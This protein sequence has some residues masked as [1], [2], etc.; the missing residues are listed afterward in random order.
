MRTYVRMGGLQLRWTGRTGSSTCSRS[1]TSPCRW[2]RPRACWCGHRACRSA[3][4]R[5]LVDEVV[6]AD[7]RLAWRSA[8]DIALAAWSETRPA[9]GAGGL[10]RR[11]P[12]DDRHAADARPHRRDRRRPHRGPG[13][14]GDVRAARRPRRAA[15]ARDQPPDGHRARA[16]CAAAGRSGP[17]LDAFLEFAGDAV[18]VAH[19]ARFDTAFLDAALRRRGG[20]RLACPVVDTVGLARRVLVPHSAAP[21]AAQPQ[22]ALRHDRASRATARCA[23]AQATAEILLVLLGRAQERGARTVDDLLALRSAGAAA[24]RCR[25]ATSRRPR[26]GR[27]AP[28]SCAR[29]AA[30]RSTSARRPTCARASARTSGPA[31]TAQ[32]RPVDEVLPAVERIDYARSGSAFEARLDELALIAGLRPGANRQGAR[33]ERAGVPAP[34]RRRRRPPRRR[35]AAR[36]RAARRPGAPRAR[37]LPGRRRAA[38]RLPACAAA[39]PR[40]RSRAP[41]SRAGWAAAWRRAAARTQRAAHAEA[42]AAVAACCASGGAAPGRPAAR[43]PRRP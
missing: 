38:P 15:A 30:C 37:R 3:V 12:G 18:L 25:A 35:R 40:H 24:A 19:N 31:G 29:A 33:P 1:G 11:R 2:A 27:R 43:A 13:A 17:A 23:D 9:A 16:T 42:V 5:P 36:R 26:R 22:R 21:V 20:T 28:T 4:A 7:A 14:R 34:G 8:D 10:L 6:R 41:A 32:D 39:A